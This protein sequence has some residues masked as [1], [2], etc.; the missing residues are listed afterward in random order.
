[1]RSSHNP[2]VCSSIPGIVFRVLTKLFILGHQTI[3]LL[4]SCSH[5]RLNVVLQTPNSCFHLTRLKPLN[6]KVRLVKC[7]S[8][9][10]LYLTLTRQL[11]YDQLLRSACSYHN[12][13]LRRA[14]CPEQLGY[15]QLQHSK[16]TSQYFTIHYNTLQHIK[17]FKHRKHVKTFRCDCNVLSLF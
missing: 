13:S 9:H 15:L 17:L 3:E 7:L 16:I 1:M 12:M 8:G 10:L 5:T 2:E 11:Y 6:H 14:P 4:S